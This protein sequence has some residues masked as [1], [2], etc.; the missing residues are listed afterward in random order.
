[1][2]DFSPST[3]NPDTQSGTGFYLEAALAMVT[4]AVVTTDTAGCVTYM[5]ASAES[6]TGKSRAQSAGQPLASVL[7]IVDATTGST[8]EAA[9]AAARQTDA[10]TIGTRSAVLLGAAERPIIVEYSVSAMRDA[11]GFVCGTV[12]VFRDVMLR[13]KAELALQASEETLL[14][15][16]EA[17]FQ[18]KERAQVTLHAIGDGVIST[19]FR[20][21]VNFLNNIAEKITGW[22]QGE[23]TGQ[24]LD[25]TF[26]LVDSTT[27]EHVSCPA[28]QAIIESRTVRVDAD[29][30]LIRRDGQ[31][32]AVEVSASPIH[33]KDK[34]V[35][36]A[37]VVAHDVTEAR[38]LSAK[39]ARLA[40]HDML[41]GLPNRTLL[42]DRLLKALERAQRNGNDV[43]LL[44]VDLDRFKPVNDSLGHAVGDQLLKEAAT[45]LLCCVRSS[46]TVSRYGGDEFIIMLSDIAR[47]EDAAVCAEKI[48]AAMNAPFAIGEHRLQISASVGIANSS[49]GITDSATLMR[50][51]D[52]AMYHAKLAGRHGFRFFTPGMDLM[53]SLDS[54]G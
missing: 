40:L 49:R 9:V 6:L 10:Q 50:N 3:L 21:R 13:R 19:D 28:M 14:A 44:F 48:V 33:D 25:Q 38:D 53:D 54:S 35:I 27:R 22:T 15:N 26:F 11:H 16:A 52:V 17:L 42:A 2:P 7:A 43:S 32:S 51:A 41:T 5:N 46:D 4:D 18:E 34:G 31:E 36:G 29:C 23:A 30:V 37:V 39:L 8:I 24:S 45:R 20:G 47:A 1:M 12:T